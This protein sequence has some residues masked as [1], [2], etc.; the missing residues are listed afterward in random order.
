MGGI[1]GEPNPIRQIVETQLA[2]TAG[3]QARPLGVDHHFDNVALALLV[4][5]SRRGLAPVGGCNDNLSYSVLL[6]RSRMHS[7]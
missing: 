3:V 5:N 6:F 7:R 1:R 4:E 2:C